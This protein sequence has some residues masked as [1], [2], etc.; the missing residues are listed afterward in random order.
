[1]GDDPVQVGSNEHRSPQVP[2]P[3]ERSDWPDC[4]VQFR[5]VV[6]LGMLLFTLGMCGPAFTV[7][8]SN[9]QQ[10]AGDGFLHDLPAG[11]LNR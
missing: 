10:N 2:W 9:D 6:T 11:K 8:D 7:D 5:Y 3:N 1:M 4:V